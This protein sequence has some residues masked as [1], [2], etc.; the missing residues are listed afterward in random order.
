MFCSFLFRKSSSL[1]FQLCLHHSGLERLVSTQNEFYSS[2][3]L[4]EIISNF[5]LVF[6]T[7]SASIKVSVVTMMLAD[8]V[9]KF[10]R[11]HCLNFNAILAGNPIFHKLYIFYDR[12]THILLILWLKVVDEIFYLLNCEFI[13]SWRK[14]LLNL[15]LHPLC[16]FLRRGRNTN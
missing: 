11:L 8:F 2:V 9:S 15:L 14:L 12:W 5:E 3:I 13:R 6:F 7:I 10:R 1:F 16:L 4:F